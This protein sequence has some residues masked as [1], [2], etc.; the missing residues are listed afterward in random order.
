MSR[1]LIN[2]ILLGVL[3][4]TSASAQELGV[5]I[6]AG[7][8]TGVSVKKWLCDDKAVDTAAAW[9]FDDHRAFQ[10]H[11]DYLWHHHI[12]PYSDCTH[13]FMPLYC[14]LGGRVG[15][16]EGN[17]RHGGRTRV[18]VRFPLGVTYL[19]EQSPIDVF[20]EVVPLFDIAPSTDL[21]LS[22]A[23]G[24]RYYVR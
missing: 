18:G 12:S 17:R 2:A 15:F 19:F 13:G 14:G 3:P 23:V 5:G 22:A 24:I 11:A 10:L 8:P 6:I 21:E 20:V 16:N 7:N 1:F 9:S 4:C